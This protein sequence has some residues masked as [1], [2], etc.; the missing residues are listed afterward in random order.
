LISTPEGDN[1][2]L[3]ALADVGFLLESRFVIWS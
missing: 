3:A 2:G 1:L